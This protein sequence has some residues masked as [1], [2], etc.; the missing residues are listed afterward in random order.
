[1]S[2]HC[3]V[4]DFAVYLFVFYSRTVRY[5][6]AEILYKRPFL[7]AFL[8]MMGGIK[9]DRDSHSFNFIT[10]SKAVLDKGGVI[11]IFPE[12]R[13]PKEGEER[14]LEFKPSVTYL[15]FESDT[16][17]IP[18]YTSGNYFKKSRVRVII[19]KEI[20]INEY[21]NEN[22]SEKENIDA[23]TKIL[24]QKIIDLGH[25]LDEKSKATIV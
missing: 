21:Y 2:N 17:I 6:M 8:K 25:L 10:K 15:A 14:P 3:S 4:Y 1:M 19:G 16:K 18:V 24:R 11:G 5:L 22:L 12:S 7:G 23:I 13:L 9:V 20:D